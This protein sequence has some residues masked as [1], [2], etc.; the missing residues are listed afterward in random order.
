MWAVGSAVP[1]FQQPG[2]MGGVGGGAAEL[3]EEVSDL[4]SGYS[5]VPV[6]FGQPELFLLQAKIPEMLFLLL[7]IGKATDLQ[8]VCQLGWQAEHTLRSFISKCCH[9]C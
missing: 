7:A 2:G 5:E 6:Q 3:P 1:R 9:F 4:A 8:N